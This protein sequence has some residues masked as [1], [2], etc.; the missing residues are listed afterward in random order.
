M[1]E[2]SI[3]SPEEFKALSK[4]VKGGK[5]Q[6]VEENIQLAVCDYL[7]AKYPHVIWFCDV[8]SGMKLPIHIATRHSKMR[9]SRGI[10]DLFIAH[11][12]KA[13][14]GYPIRLGDDDDGFLFEYHGLFIEL[15]TESLRLKNGSVASSNHILEQKK[16]LNRF[17]D[18]HYKAEFACGYSEAIKIIDE[19]L[20]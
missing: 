18:L 17:I 6:K 15:K 4:K 14:H 1:T 20:R 19:Y 16:I 10:P 12:G 2:Q 7:R 3:F 5:R 9:S 13:F 8:A 11:P